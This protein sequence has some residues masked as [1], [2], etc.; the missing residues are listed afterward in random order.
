MKRRSF[1]K[2][3]VV[4]TFAGFTVRAVDGMEGIQITPVT[5]EELY[6]VDP[7]PAKPVSKELLDA[8]KYARKLMDEQEIPAEG[9]YGASIIGQPHVVA[10]QNKL[11]AA[12]RVVIDANS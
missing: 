4:G 3:M 2:G 10:A 8:I 12:M 9:L 7:L 5:N 11:N 6:R 1:L